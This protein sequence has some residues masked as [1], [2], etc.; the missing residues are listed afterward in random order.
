MERILTAAGLA[1][2]T[3]T[4][5]FILYYPGKKCQLGSTPQNFVRK[6]SDTTT[7]ITDLALTNII[8]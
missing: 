4:M 5:T 3:T 1:V 8:G 6:F 7:I 2:P